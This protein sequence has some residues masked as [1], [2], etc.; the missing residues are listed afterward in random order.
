MA[1]SNRIEFAG[2]FYRVMAR[3]N[4]ME[5]TYQDEKGVSV[6]IFAF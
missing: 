5:A 2:A 3:G 6:H 4:H 1:R